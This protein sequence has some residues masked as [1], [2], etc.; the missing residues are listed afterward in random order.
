MRKLLIT[1]TA[2]A[3]FSV[4]TAIP[5]YAAVNYGHGLQNPSNQL[6]TQSSTALITNPAV[7]ATVS[8]NTAPN[9]TSV[10]I[11]DQTTG[12]T[13]DTNVPVNNGTFSANVPGVVTGDV[14]VITPYVGMTAEPTTT[15][16]V[17]F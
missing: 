14:L 1:S 2:V 11:V 8:G 3:L 7:T 15:I 12:N 17:T 13:L 16:D 5:A 6:T 9:I 10:T 4:C